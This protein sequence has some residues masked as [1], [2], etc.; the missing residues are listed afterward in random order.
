MRKFMLGVVSFL[1]ALTLAGV[2]FLAFWDANPP[3]Q[4]MEI[5]VPN[6]RLSSQ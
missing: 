3:T 2:V 6:E 5:T 1:M 4:H